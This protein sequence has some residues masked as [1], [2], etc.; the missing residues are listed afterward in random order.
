[1]H[2]TCVYGSD[3]EFLSMALPF[4]DNGLAADD[5][6][7]AATTTANVELLRRALGTRAGRI[8][9]IDSLAFGRRP[10]ERLTAVDR[11]WRRHAP[12][13]GGRVRI[14][15]EPIWR[16]RSR[17]EVTA[18]T[19]LES[20]LNVL[21][22][23]R[24]IQVVCPYDSRVVP[25]PIIADAQRTHPEILVGE[26]TMASGEY[27]HPTVFTAKGPEPESLLVPANPM[28]GRFDAVDLAGV[29][30][31]AMSYARRLYVPGA[32]ARDLVFAVNEVTTNVI[33]HG[34]GYG[35]VWFWTEE[36]ELICEVTDDTVHGPLAPFEGSPPPLDQRG[37]GLWL[38][39]QL[40]DRVH[41]ASSDGR[42]VV[43]MHMLLRS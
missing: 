37:R 24:D 42:T 43:R 31:E 40:C 19:C 17:R 22:G 5:P 30:D 8:D 21:F 15:A 12:R 7:L 1:M 18:W 29:R 41:M 35:N 6:V 23:G 26:R 20:T 36:D 2:Q 27:V 28:G 25:E 3:E 10:P 38:V 32:R 4:I 16:G 14:I 39:R 9:Y 33:L 11:Y 13:T 34:A